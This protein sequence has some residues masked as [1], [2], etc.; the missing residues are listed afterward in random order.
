MIDFAA[1]KAWI[2]RITRLNDSKILTHHGAHNDHNTGWT[3][4]NGNT[5]TQAMVVLY[6]AFVG[7]S[8]DLVGMV[9]LHLLI[10]G[11]VAGTAKWARPGHPLPV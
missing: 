10:A 6:L 9:C 5:A 4:S 2:R 7:V 11:R 1:K 3:S 8:A